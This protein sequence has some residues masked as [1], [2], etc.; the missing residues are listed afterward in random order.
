MPEE[1][2]Y[3]QDH[4]ILTSENHGDLIFTQAFSSYLKKRKFRV[5]MCKKADPESKGKIEKVIENIIFYGITI[6]LQLIQTAGVFVIAYFNDAFA[7]LSFFLIGFFFVR[8]F[9]GETFHLNST[10][11]CTTF[12]WTIFYIITA[13]IPSIYVSV[14]LCIVLGSMLAIYM[15]YIVVKEE[16]K[17]QED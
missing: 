7:E 5:H 13:L 1:I 2:V 17:C 16:E 14:L 11:T 12:T 8:S 3:D 4:L 10:I 15:N 6:P 9:L